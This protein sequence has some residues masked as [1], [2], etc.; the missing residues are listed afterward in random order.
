M[1]HFWWIHIECDECDCNIVESDLILIE[2][3]WIDEI[4]AKMADKIIHWSESFD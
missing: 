1:K 2:G 4:R 3:H